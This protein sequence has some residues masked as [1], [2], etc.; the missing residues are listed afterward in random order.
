MTQ[1]ICFEGLGIGTPS[2][3]KR[4]L[5]D[6]LGLMQVARPDYSIWRGSFATKEEN[7]PE[8][9]ECKKR[10]LIAHSMGGAT[11]IAWCKRWGETTNVR[12]GVPI[13]LLLTLD[14]RPLHRTYIKPA[15]VKR[16]VNFYRRSLWMRGYP[17]D[18]AENHIVTC[19]HTFVPSL[20]QVLK[21]V[22]GEL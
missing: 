18:G 22:R 5:L 17:V 14:P 1:I 20:P 2:H 13:D 12:F 15:N 19:G 10:I 7:W 21:L 9:I 8:P 16:A 3:I 6:P 11:A 4:G